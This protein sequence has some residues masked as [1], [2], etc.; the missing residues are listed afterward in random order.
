MSGMLAFIRHLFGAMLTGFFFTGIAAG[1]LCA[2]VLFVPFTESGQK[3]P[4]FKWGM[5]GPAH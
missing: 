2:V 4:A 1:I 5:N 3:A